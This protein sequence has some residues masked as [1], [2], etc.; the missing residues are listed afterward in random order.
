MFFR[1]Q[2]LL[3]LSGFSFSKKKTNI[4]S[5]SSSPPSLVSSSVTVI[6]KVVL[7]GAE[8]NQNVRVVRRKVDG[9]LFLVSLERVRELLRFESLVE[10]KKLPR[11]QLMTPVRLLSGSIPPQ[12]W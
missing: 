8:F 1:K 2:K 9:A 10:H 12:L 5:I 11:E 4:R 3:T 6:G 7:P